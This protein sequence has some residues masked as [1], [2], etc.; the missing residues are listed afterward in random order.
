MELEN[1]IA[2][3][4]AEQRMRDWQIQLKDE[5]RKLRQQKEDQEDKLRV[6]QQ[7]RELEN[8]IKKAKADKKNF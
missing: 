1:L 5:I 2:K 8:E 6:R 7:E 4:K 3:Q